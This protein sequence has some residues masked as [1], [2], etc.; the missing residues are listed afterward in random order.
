MVEDHVICFL[1][2][3]HNPLFLLAT[4]KGDP[5]FLLSL[6]G[7]NPKQKNK[8]QKRQK[9]SNRIVFVKSGKEERDG[10]IHLGNALY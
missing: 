2:T 3:N 7:F 8:I 10:W 1:M 6:R 4:Q 9:A 5:L